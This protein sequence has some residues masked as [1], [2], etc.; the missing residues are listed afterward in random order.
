MYFIGYIFK[1]IFLYIKIGVFF[2][3]FSESF[4]VFIDGPGL[5]L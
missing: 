4:R 3:L 5:M 2:L 1:G